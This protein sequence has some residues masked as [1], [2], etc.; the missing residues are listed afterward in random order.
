M[1]TRIPRNFCAY[2]LFLTDYSS[3]QF[4]FYCL[5]TVFSAATQYMYVHTCHAVGV[6]SK[7][8]KKKQ[9]R[10]FYVFFFF[11]NPAKVKCYY[12]RDIG[13][14]RVLKRTAIIH[15]LDIHLWKKCSF[16]CW[17]Q[18]YTVSAKVCLQEIISVASWNGR[19]LNRALLL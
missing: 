4:L 5:V 15:F 14:S 8:A 17:R 18:R 6:T 19:S 7:Q 16:M 10:A 9:K 12:C 2:V 1:H 11:V 3:F 13:Y